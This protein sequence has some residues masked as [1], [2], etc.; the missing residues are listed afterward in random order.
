M[1][2]EYYRWCVFKYTNFSNIHLVNERKTTIP[3]SQELILSGTDNHDF[4]SKGEVKT[5]VI[6]LVK[7]TSGKQ[8]VILRL[9]I[10]LECAFSFKVIY[11]LH[12]TRPMSPSWFP[13]IKSCSTTSPS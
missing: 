6:K 3:Y 5:K 2:A 1:F 11:F 10:I 8:S 4:L 7:G 12:V 13:T 9:L